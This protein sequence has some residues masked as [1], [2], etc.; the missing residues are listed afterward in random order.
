[1]NPLSLQPARIRFGLVTSSMND[2]V[3]YPRYVRDDV[4]ALVKALQQ[5]E[6]VEDPFGSVEKQLKRQGF[7]LVLKVV[8]K[9]SIGW[10]I[11]P[12]L[13]NQTGE[14]PAKT[15]SVYV[16]IDPLKDVGILRTLERLKSALMTLANEANLNLKLKL[17][18]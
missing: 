15:E 9:G 13:T 14:M 18:A 5:P 1:M 12:C 10:V 6:N 2:S 11:N 4:K 7:D 17:E 3:A 16:Y 8:K